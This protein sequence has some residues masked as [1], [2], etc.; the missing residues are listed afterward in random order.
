MKR[1][2]II[3]NS[4]A[5]KSTL[6]AALAKKAG[7]PLI[8]SDPFY[9]TANW[10][11]VSPEA[12]RQRVTDATATNIWVIDGNFDSE[13]D[14]VWARADTVVWLDYTL[15]L[16]MRRVCRRN[17][18]WWLTGQTVWSGSR[19]TWNRAWSGIRHARRTFAQ[20]Q[21]AYPA[22]LADFPHLTILRFRSPHQVTHW[23][24]NS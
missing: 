19:M 12:V 5:G 23:M 17:L 13:R 21:A 20:K 16:V 8:A 18:L 14:V 9:W 15:A 7:L 2:V 24:I 1:V 22:F 11:A 4:G 3:G 10:G 6:A